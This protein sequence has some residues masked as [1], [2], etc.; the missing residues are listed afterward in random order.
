MS[1][2]TSIN[3]KANF[4]M[5]KNTSIIINSPECKSRMH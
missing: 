3:K 1:N 2:D 4:L 5:L